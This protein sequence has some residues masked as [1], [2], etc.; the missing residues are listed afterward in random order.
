MHCYLTKYIS[1]LFND[2]PPSQITFNGI[3]LCQTP[4]TS[5]EEAC[6]FIASD[7]NAQLCSRIVQ[8]LETLASKELDYEKKV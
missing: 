5:E 2:K 6:E 3:A 4:V 8:W 7:Q 1:S